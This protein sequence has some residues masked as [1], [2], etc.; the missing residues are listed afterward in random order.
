MANTSKRPLQSDLLK[1]IIRLAK[2]IDGTLQMK[3]DILADPLKNRNANQ[4]LGAMTPRFK[5]VR[6]ELQHINQTL[7]KFTKPKEK[8]VERVP[9]LEIK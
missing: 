5:N 1:D 3:A 7:V 2:L 6:R 8:P 9:E 4:T